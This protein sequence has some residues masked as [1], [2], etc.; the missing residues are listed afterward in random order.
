[1][2]EGLDIVSAI[3]IAMWQDSIREHTRQIYALTNQIKTLKQLTSEAKGFTY[4]T[5]F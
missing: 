5:D 4:L 1:M 2:E 3:Q